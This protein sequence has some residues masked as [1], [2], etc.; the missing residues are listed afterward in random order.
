[1]RNA[2]LI[3]FVLLVMCIAS[4]NAQK[5]R[6][7]PAHVMGANSCTECHG[8][9][10]D[11]WRASR[12]FATFKT[13]E[14]SDKANEIADLLE[15]D[16]LTSDSLCVECH[17]VLQKKGSKT[18]AISGISCESCHG[19]ARDW[20]K[21][22]NK[23]KISRE[24][25][26]EISEKAGM[27][28]PGNLYAVARNCFD[29]HIIKHEELVNKGGHPAFSKDFDLSGWL[30]GEVRHNFMTD[31]VPVK[32]SGTENR[33]ASPERRRMLF[34]MGQLLSLEYSLRAVGKAT[35][36][37]AKPPGGAKA[38]GIQQALRAHAL[39]GNIAKLNK[40]VNTAEVTAILEV[41]DTVVLKTKNEAQLVAAA[42]KISVL[43]KK[44]AISHDGS[45]FAAI[46]NLIP[47]P[48]GK[49]FIP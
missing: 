16:D 37:K 26:K 45:K 41:V 33:E 34:M 11:A 48:H 15:V 6:L 42:D 24:Q 21:E 35:T 46:D 14:D 38:F 27:I 10:I 18:S 40:Q 13:L 20:I 43:T 5:P 1:M 17:F 23:E 3:T 47:K 9:E 19:A 36:A 28:Y 7:D 31:A 2:V 12:H 29:C 39:K 49:T 4:G 22:H 44:F 8:K 30:Q 25:R 32:K